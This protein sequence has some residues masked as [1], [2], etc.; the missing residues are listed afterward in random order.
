[1][2]LRQAVQRGSRPR[3]GAA[4]LH[5]SQPLPGL[6]DLKPRR[7]PQ[8]GEQTGEVIGNPMVR[9]R[10]QF[11]RRRRCGRAQ[12]RCEI[13]DGKVGFVAD[14]RSNREL[15]CGYGARYAFA[16]EGGEVFERSAAARQHNQV[17][18]P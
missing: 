15:G 14:S 18:R 17:G 10:D 3:F 9:F 1:M 6:Q 16:V 12:V 7:S 11:C 8:P 4:R 5:T 2:N 13:G